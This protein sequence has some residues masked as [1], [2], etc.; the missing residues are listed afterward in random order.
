VAF[1]PHDIWFGSS[2]LERTRVCLYSGHCESV[3]E[4]FGKTID[5]CYRRK[6]VWISRKIWFVHIFYRRIDSRSSSCFTNERFHEGAYGTPTDIKFKQLDGSL[7]SASFTA[8]TPAMRETERKVLIKLQWVGNNTLV[9][10][11]T[12]T[13]TP[14]FKSKE[15]ILRQVADSF[16]AV[17]A[18]K[19][20]LR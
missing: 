9:L 7:Y 8:Y 4:Y 11:V 1:A 13:T 19:S 3:I 5:E 6:C 12:G 10:L 2:G 20:G 16:E 18:P 14:R 17:A 15:K